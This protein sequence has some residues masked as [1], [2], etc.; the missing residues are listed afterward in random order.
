MCVATIQAVSQ[1]PPVVFVCVTDP[2]DAGFVDNL[3]KPGGNAIGF[4][5]FEYGFAAKKRP[6]ASRCATRT[7]AHGSGYNKRREILNRA[8]HPARAVPL[9]ASWIV[10]PTN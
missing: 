6:R 1:P 9:R 10:S 4:M 3:A 2:A 5:L 8:H 7:N